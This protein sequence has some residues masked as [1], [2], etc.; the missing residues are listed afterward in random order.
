VPYAV[1]FM[2][3]MEVG[4][5]GASRVYGYPSIVV[6]AVN[7]LVPRQLEW[8]ECH[9][10][11]GEMYRLRATVEGTSNAVDRAALIVFEH[12][13][14]GVG[15]SIGQVGPHIRLHT[16][17][18]LSRVD[19]VFTVN[20]E[21]RR[22]GLRTVE[23]P[24]TAVIRTLTIERIDQER[25]NVDSFLSFD[26]EAG[27]YE[28]LSDPLDARVWCKTPRGEYG[29]RRIC[30]I[31]DE[32][33]LTGNFLV[34]F[35]SCAQE[36]ERRLREIVDFL[37]SSGHEVHAHLHTNKVADLWG[38]D[39][40]DSF[41]LEGSDYE[42]L[43]RLLDFTVRSYERCVGRPPRLFRSGSYMMGSALV[44][45]AGSLGIEALSNVRDNVGDPRLGGD[46]VLGRE[47]FVWEN[48]VVEIP[49]DVSSPERGSFDTF[50]RKRADA[51]M[52]KTNHRTCNIVMHSWSLIR[53]GDG[54]ADE[55]A[56]DHIERFHQICDLVNERGRAWGYGDY[57]D[58]RAPIHEMQRLSHIVAKDQPGALDGDL[59]TC[60][61]CD[62]SF[63]RDVMT[64]EHCPSC[65]SG[66]LH[67]QV[68]FVIDSYAI[69]LRGRAIAT[70]E[71]GG[72]SQI[73]LATGASQVEHRASGSLDFAI[74][75]DHLVAVAP[76]PAQIDAMSRHYEL[77]SVPGLDPVLGDVATVYFG[78]RHDN[79]GESEASVI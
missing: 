11:P 74:E 35:G 54:G 37:A 1:S 49:V 25:P 52:R 15:L 4:A 6:S 42:M 18:G 64:T 40:D 78:R 22:Y 5:L 57:L 63:V 3:R 34:D 41:R 51:V 38:V 30:R 26:V 65:S 66:S 13:G 21:V 45:A 61:V 50:L 71:P 7:V 19:R 12:A 8:R 9:L 10:I 73:R 23:N 47:P 29:I 28:V 33:G 43:R 59:G 70:S 69:P 16:S 48:G 20:S 27:I 72:T 24:N 75:S 2:P 55:A 14:D 58:D 31:L 60:N 76:D 62:T 46:P 77:V 53:Q 39:H 68:R 44:L 32:H 36:G 79:N 56:V 17:P 67:R